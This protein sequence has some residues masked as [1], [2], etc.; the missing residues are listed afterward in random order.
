VF[1]LLKNTNNPIS[2]H[3]YIDED[4]KETNSSK[5]KKPDQSSIKNANQIQ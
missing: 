1:L 3:R 2:V 5:L 4:E